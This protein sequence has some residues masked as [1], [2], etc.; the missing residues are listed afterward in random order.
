MGCT[1][2]IYPEDLIVDKT[3]IPKNSLSFIKVKKHRRRNATQY[4]NKYNWNIWNSEKIT[5][6]K[7]R[8]VKETWVHIASFDSS[9]DSSYDSSVVQRI[10]YIVS[11]N[12]NS[13]IIEEQDMDNRERELH[14]PMAVSTSSR[15][16]VKELSLT[17]VCNKYQDNYLVDSE[18]PMLVLD[19]MRNIQQIPLS[20]LYRSSRLDSS[21][22]SCLNTIDE[23][24]TDTL[25]PG[26]SV[27]PVGPVGPGCS[28]R[29]LKQEILFVK[30]CNTKRRVSTILMPFYDC[31]HKKLSD[32]SISNHKIFDSNIA[33][34]SKFLTQLIKI[35]VK[36]IELLLI[37]E[38][39]YQ[40]KVTDFARTYDISLDFA[41]AIGKA[42]IYALISVDSSFLSTDRQNSW[43]CIYSYFF[44]T[45]NLSFE[46]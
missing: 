1:V 13:K 42:L 26:C 43:I 5:V 17:P 9:H 15:N 14:L 4:D 28:V 6:D 37:D 12:G 46:R 20:P 8:D 36:D 34:Q 41:D 39:I 25:G 44:Q 22:S 32:F 35:L 2:S 11:V 3:K 38:K 23:K 40:T 21:G 7:I 45:L 24:A 18:K 33:T 29:D 30:R 31:F 16:P 27:G 10:K 19:F